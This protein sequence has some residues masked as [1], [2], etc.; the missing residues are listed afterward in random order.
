M[1]L[2]NAKIISN[3]FNH[4]YVGT[5]H[6]LVGILNDDGEAKRILKSMNVTLDGVKALIKEYIG[7][8]DIDMSYPLLEIPITPRT[9][10]ILE[11]SISEA[12]SAN[13]TYVLPE[14]ILLSLIKDKDSVAFI[15]LSNLEVN[16]SKIRKQLRDYLGYEN[17]GIVDKDKIEN[18]TDTVSMVNRWWKEGH[19]PAANEQSLT[20][21]RPSSNFGCAGM[22]VISL[23]SFNFNRPLFLLP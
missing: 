9:K 12:R 10:R 14:H 1:V 8:G 21:R 13:V 16:F 18:K 20:P 19:L 17:D 11:E 7:I 4:G 6:I 3:E 22:D 2:D 5:E 15:I 23:A